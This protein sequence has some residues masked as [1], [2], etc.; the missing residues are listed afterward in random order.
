MEAI[1]D[2]NSSA[3]LRAREL[4]LRAAIEQSHKETEEA[5]MSRHVAGAILSTRVYLITPCELLP[6]ELGGAQCHGWGP[7][8]PDL[9]IGSHFRGLELDDLSNLSHSAILWLC[10]LALCKSAKPAHRRSPVV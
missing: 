7:G 3:G 9:L 4:C 2:R 1:S 8:Q 5:G 6:R 10:Q